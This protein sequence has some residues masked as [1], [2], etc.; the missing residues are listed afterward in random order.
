[1]NSLR[2]F[3]T[4]SASVKKRVRFEGNS[5]CAH[6][7]KKVKFSDLSSDTAESE[8]SDEI[9]IGMV[10]DEKRPVNHKPRSIAAQADQESSDDVSGSADSED[11][12][13]SES[14]SIEPE[15]TYEGERNADGEPH[16]L[17]VE[18]IMVG[19]KCVQRYE[20]SFENGLRSGKGKI[21]FP[22]IHCCLQIFHRFSSPPHS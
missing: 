1:M 8:S 5:Y 17:G 14:E 2:T 10:L 6:I 20:G 16:G 21:I 15:S 4:P 9:G 19:T 22:G 13:V 7:M 3:E 12:D 18:C 11:L